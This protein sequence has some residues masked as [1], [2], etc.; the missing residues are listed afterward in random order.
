MKPLR[1]LFGAHL[2]EVT[3]S[4][5]CKGNAI[6]SLTGDVRKGLVLRA[7]IEKC[8]RCGQY[9]GRLTDGHNHTTIDPDYMIDTS[10]GCLHK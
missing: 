6:S 7:T 5:L 8:S 3:S 1:C 4:S 9:R 10:N 2:W